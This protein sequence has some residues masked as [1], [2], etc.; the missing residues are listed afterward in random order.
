MRKGPSAR[1]LLATAPRLATAL[2]AKREPTR[3]LV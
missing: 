1:A 2:T 3:A